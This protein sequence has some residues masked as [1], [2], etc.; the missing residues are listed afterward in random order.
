MTS[1]ISD[2]AKAWRASPGEEGAPANPFCDLRLAGPPTS[3]ARAGPDL[4]SGIGH[5]PPLSGLSWAARRQ[6]SGWMDV[7]SGRRWHG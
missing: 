7:R 5:S 3:G 4:A 1:D 6:P 2:V